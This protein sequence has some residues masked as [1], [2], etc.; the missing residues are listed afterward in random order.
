ME[1]MAAS[2]IVTQYVN[3]KDLTRIWETPNKAKC[4]MIHILKRYLATLNTNRSE[5]WP[6]VYLIRIAVS[7]LIT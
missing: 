3:T 5:F 6:C 1:L 7:L 2:K 4:F